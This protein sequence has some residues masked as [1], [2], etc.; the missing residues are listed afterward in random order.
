MFFSFVNNYSIKGELITNTLKIFTCKIQLTRY[1][2]LNIPESYLNKILHSNW[3][4]NEASKQFWHSDLTPN[5]RWVE[6]PDRVSLIGPRLCNSQREAK[7]GYLQ[8]TTNIICLV[9]CKNPAFQWKYYCRYWEL[10]YTF[11]KWQNFNHCVINSL[12]N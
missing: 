9:L 6:R 4:L 2:L 10:T 7:L 12:S 5:K 1:A 8:L 11:K 3:I